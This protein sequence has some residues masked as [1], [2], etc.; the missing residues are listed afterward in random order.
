MQDGV[1]LVKETAKLLEKQ[2]KTPEPIQWHCQ[3]R[4]AYIHHTLRFTEEEK[5]YEEQNALLA[6]CSSFDP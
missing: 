2:V 5:I 4:H 3:K 1:K 6:L